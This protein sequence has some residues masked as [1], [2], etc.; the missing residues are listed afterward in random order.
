MVLETVPVRE[1]FVSRESRAPGILAPRRIR[2]TREDAHRVMELVD[3]QYN[4]TGALRL[5]MLS[6]YELYRLTEFQWRQIRMPRHTSR[7]T[8]NEPR[9]LADTVASILI[10]APVVHRA[11]TTDDIEQVRDAGRAA[12]ELFHGLFSMA[13]KERI[14]MAQPSIKEQMVFYAL[15]RGFVTIM[16]TLTKNE[17]GET[18]PQVEVWDPLNVYWG[19]SSDGRGSGANHHGLA[20]ICHYQ[21]LDSWRLD[22]RFGD[23]RTAITGGLKPTYMRGSRPIYRV[24]DFYDREFN[25][26]VVDDKVVDKKRHFGMGYVPATVRPVGPAPLVLDSMNT[27]AHVEDYGQSIFAHNRDLYPK[28]NALLS[29]KFERVMRF[30]D[31]AVATK[32]RTGRYVLPPNVS[33]PFDRG[34]RFNQNTVNEEEIVALQEPDLPRDSA[35][36][37]ASMQ[38]MMQK[39]GVPNVVHGQST[40]PSSG[41]NTSLLLGSQRYV[42]ER[43]LDA[44]VA[45]HTGMEEFWRR[46]FSSGF[47]EPIRMQG[48]I[49]RGRPYNRLIEPSTISMAPAPIFRARIKNPAE[50]EQRMMFAQMLKQMGLGD[51]LYILDEVLEM[52]DPDE[53]LDRIALQKA[54]NAL[55]QTQLY[56]AIKAA[57]EA[58][59]EQLAKLLMGAMM[60]FMQGQPMQG[61][62]TGAPGQMG[63][64]GGPAQLPPGGGGVPGSTTAAGGSPRS[65]QPNPSDESQLQ[66]RPRPEGVR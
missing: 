32:S 46:Q 20:W 10:S 3:A 38:V 42:V 66:G 28:Y 61:D 54:K 25:I 2:R 14:V 22:A 34:Q 36:I 56:E 51:D 15:I 35:E 29:V 59:L 24:Y 48:E 16:H 37:E 55:P 19:I 65:G 39:G 11:P 4:E 47:F 60:Q 5:R 9:T 27:T 44:L 52:D 30:I 57:E 63:G 1:E 64:G 41:Y 8:S 43:F 45:A 21:D 53:M 49:A 26:V 12:E 18:V 7:F 13:D 23:S 62:G 17:Q 58:G 50:L 6:D 40:T 33:N 31:P